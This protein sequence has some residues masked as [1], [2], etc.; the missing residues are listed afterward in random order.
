MALFGNKDKPNKGGLLGD[1]IQSPENDRNW[2]LYKWRPEGEAAGNTQRENSIRMGSN[3]T[4]RQGEVAVFQYAGTKGSGG[5]QDYIEGFFSDSLKTSNLPILAGIMGAAFGGGSKFPAQV[6]FINMAGVNQV[7]FGVPYFPMFDPRLPDHN[8]NVA[9]RGTI[10]FRI[11]DAKIFATLHTLVDFDMEKFSARIKDSVIGYVQDSMMDIQQRLGRPLIQINTYRREIRDIL[12]SD[13]S[14]SLSST[15]GVTLTEL[16]ISAI[17]VDQDSEGYARLAKLTKDMTET[18]IGTQH[19]LSVTGMQDAYAMQKKGLEAA[20]DIN[21][22]HMAESAR[23]SREEGQYAQ[24][25]QTDMGGFA[26]HQLQQQENIAKSAAG[27]MGQMGQASGVSMGGGAGGFNPGAMMAGMAMGGAVG[28]GMAGMMG[29]VFN[30]MGQ[31]V[32]GQTPPAMPA[33]APAAP[34]VAPP[35]AS[36]SYSI[37]VNGQT[38]GPYD[39]NALAQMKQSGQFTAQSMV[40]RD[41]MA[42]W[43]AAGTVQDLAPFFASP[44]PPAP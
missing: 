35:P 27:A 26:L 31:Q 19:T 23:I 33:A 5:G 42:G 13:L 7:K 16:N 21:L 10:T 40:W 28:Q 25:T 37:A 36:A 20:Q 1:M 15:Y 30:Q 34:P 43:Q 38:Y 18:T 6:Y 22:E 9:V 12:Q 4:V 44:P 32:P 8:V 3:L 11:P 17:E 39:M 14:G 2:L 24:H 29:N 41:G